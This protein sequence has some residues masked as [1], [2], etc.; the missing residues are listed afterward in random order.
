MRWIT[1]LCLSL[2]AA[3]AW[4]EGRYDKLDASG[5]HL[6][7]TARQWDCLLDRQTGLLWETKTAAGLRGRGHTYSWYQPGNA[8]AK[9]VAGW[10]QCEVVSCDTYAYIEEI[11]RMRLCGQNDWRLPE[12]TELFTLFYAPGL[13]SAAYFPDMDKASY[14]SATLAPDGSSPIFV[15]FYGK[16]ISYWHPPQQA[17]RV[18]LVS[19]RSLIQE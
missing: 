10:G 4:A 6:P 16:G 13:V 8:Q 12:E 18:R 15:A 11:N 17:K 19:G 5:S 14:W 3:L 7:A 9:G 1:L 2:F